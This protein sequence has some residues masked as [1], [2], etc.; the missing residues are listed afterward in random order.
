MALKYTKE[1]GSY[2]VH[3][4]PVDTPEILNGSSD[5]ISNYR[6]WKLLIYFNFWKLTTVSSISHSTS[7]VSTN[8]QNIFSV[9]ATFSFK[10]RNF[11]Y[12]K[13]KKKNSRQSPWWRMDS[14]LAEKVVDFL[15][16]ENRLVRLPSQGTFKSRQF[17]VL[18]LQP[19]KETFPHY[20]G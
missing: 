9:G 2:L 10:Y 5:N 11:S 4:W 1:T 8:R 7:F 18:D 16:G 20:K 6:L 12:R 3:S 14:F 17:E 19:V 15:G 13:M